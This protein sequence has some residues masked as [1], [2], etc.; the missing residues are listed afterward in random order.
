[1]KAEVNHSLEEILHGE[2]QLHQVKVKNDR[3]PNVTP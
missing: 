3:I 2:Q 1:M